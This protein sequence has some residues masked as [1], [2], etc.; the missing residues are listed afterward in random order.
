MPTQKT[1]QRIIDLLLVSST[2]SSV[3]RDV[4]GSSPIWHRRQVDVRLADGQDVGTRTTDKPFEPDLEDSGCDEGS[5][6]AEGGGQEVFGGSAMDLEEG[7][8]KAGERRR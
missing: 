7:D 2:D 5:K 4:H 8:E 6:E 1:L 3:V